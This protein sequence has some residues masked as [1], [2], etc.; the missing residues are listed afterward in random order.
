L[1]GVTTTLGWPFPRL[2]EVT[3]ASITGGIMKM[4]AR[5]LTAR[6]FG[7]TRMGGLYVYWAFGK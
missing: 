5:H 2:I 3:S 6:M 4:F 1:T 7:R